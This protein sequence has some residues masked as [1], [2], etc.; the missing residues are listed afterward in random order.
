MSGATPELEPVYSPF[1]RI[2]RVF[3]V[4]S[5]VGLCFAIW[6]GI[7]PNVLVIETGPVGGS[8]YNAALKYK[9]WL[10]ARGVNVRIKAI[11][12]SM[13]IVRDVNAGAQGVQIGFTAQDVNAADFPEARSLGASEL[14]PL[15]IFRRA[16][17]GS[18]VSL[19]ELRGQRIVMPPEHSA[20]SQAA[21][22]V[23]RHYG[24]TAENAHFSFL[25]LLQ[26]A[27]AL[28][29]REHDVGMFM[30]APNNPVIID[31]ARSDGLVLQSIPEAEALSRLEPYLVSAVLPQR[32]YDIRA[33]TPSSDIRL[34]A[35][36]VNVIASTRVHPALIYLMLG[37][38]SEVHQGATYVSRAGEYPNLVHVSLPLHP[39]A[40]EYSKSGIPWIYRNLPLWLSGVLDFY[41]ATVVVVLIIPQ[42]WSLY[43]NIK[44]PSKFVFEALAHRVIFR[45]D[46][47]LKRGKELSWL[48]WKL[49]NFAKYIVVP[50]DQ[51][52]IIAS[53][54][55]MIDTRR[56]G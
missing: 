37:A 25:P 50:P 32:I 33:G 27:S 45:M 53:R 42:I 6:R 8:Y 12:D 36:K 24:I 39:L 26:A 47:K 55:D 28:K 1:R 51:R 22:A 5:L 14:Q 48:D 54:I 17:L 38:I 30:L 23:L 18:Q 40:F 9:A 20:T 44:N 34:L 2:R 41:L 43:S 10:E 16:A 13:N 56:S 29:E 31:L 52:K 21:V 19:A 3:L 11:D 4:L 7:P 46:Q 49:F 15:F 35:A